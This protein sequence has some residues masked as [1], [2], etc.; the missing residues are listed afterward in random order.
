MWS[1]FFQSHQKW[2]SPIRT[3]NGKKAKVPKYFYKY[4]IMP[5]K[6]N[7]I[8]MEKKSFSPYV[9]EI[10]YVYAIKR[11]IKETILNG[12][13]KWNFEIVYFSSLTDNTFQSLL[14]RYATEFKRFSKCGNKL[15][16]F[17]TLRLFTW[18]VI[19]DILS[20]HDWNLM[21]TLRL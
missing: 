7:F 17:V 2:K 21:S 6:S 13:L 20:C 19:N 11:L 10:K 5:D 12:N 14:L 16:I 9:M 3:V 18:V 8:A 4:S 1:D 15:S